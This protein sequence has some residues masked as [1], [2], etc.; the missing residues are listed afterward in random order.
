MCG[1]AV[2]SRSA[3]VC[4]SVHVGCFV[5]KAD[6]RVVRILIVKSVVDCEQCII[7]LVLVWFMTAGTLKL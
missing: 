3:G 4:R 2:D 7:G 1:R 6:V 5:D